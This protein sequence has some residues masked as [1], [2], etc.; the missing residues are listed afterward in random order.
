VLAVG[1]DLV[2]ANALKAVSGVGFSVAA[3]VWF[4]DRAEVAWVAGGLMSL[5]SMVGAWVGA[6]L[7]AR[8]RSKVWVFR[9][10]VVTIVGEI[11]H[12]LW[13]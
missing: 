4:A 9:V 5:G 13:R 11:V 1:Y 12:L 10:L 6:K 3:I 7:A 8:E 2:G